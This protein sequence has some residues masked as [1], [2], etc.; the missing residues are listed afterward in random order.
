MSLRVGVWVLVFVCTLPNIA[1]A[2]A[3]T[4]YQGFNSSSVLLASEHAE[5]QFAACEF[6][7]GQFYDAVTF[8]VIEGVT[9]DPASGGCSARLDDNSVVA[10]TVN[11]DSASCTGDV[12][13]DFARQVCADLP[14]DEHTFAVLLA[15]FLWGSF[16]GGMLVGERLGS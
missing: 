4:F 7:Q 14:R 15:A 1:S 11:S 12:A 3:Y 6:V 8:P 9:Y 10:V 2:D 5:T 13:F 16:I